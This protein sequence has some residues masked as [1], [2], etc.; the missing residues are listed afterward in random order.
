MGVP[1]R[2]SLRPGP[3]PYHKLGVAILEGAP[4]VPVALLLAI[5]HAALHSVL[6]LR[7]QS[8]GG[9]WASRPP[10]PRRQEGEAESHQGSISARGSP[11][12]RTH[13]GPRAVGKGLQ[14]GR[15][16]SQ[17]HRLISELEKGQRLGAALPAASLGPS[18]SSDL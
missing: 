2:G 10:R 15:G 9:R 1:S 12:P 13:T 18:L 16:C 5:H 4:R 14:C 6:D 11:A 3:E 7:R 17:E 8:R